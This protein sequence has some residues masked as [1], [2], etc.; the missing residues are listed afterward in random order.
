MKPSQ[1]LFLSFPASREA[2]RSGI[3]YWIPAFAG[4]T[5]LMSGCSFHPLYGT[6]GNP[7]QKSNVAE[8]QQIRVD[9]IADR[10]GQLL[11]NALIDQLQPEGV[12]PPP[13]YELI[14]TYNEGQADLGLNNNATTTRG[15][16]TFS[17]NFKLRDIAD[18]KSETSGSAQEIVGYNIQYSEFG[19]IVSRDDAEQRAVRALADNIAA[20]LAFYF[21]NKR[22]NPERAKA[23]QDRSAKQPEQMIGPTG[24]LPQSNLGFP[25]PQSNPLTN[26]NP[27]GNQT[28]INQGP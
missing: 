11:R 17:A 18:G 1:F 16:L 22:D 10:A 9:T 15:Q 2:A 12:P 20:R 21:E 7:D 28:P 25:E 3:Q 6:P 23:E 27:L 4:M 13:V 8:L 14:I 5:L 24:Q 19:T 26:A